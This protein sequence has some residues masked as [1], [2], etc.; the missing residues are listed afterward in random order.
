MSTSS[1][2]SSWARILSPGD[3]ILGVAAVPWLLVTAFY[4]ARD[5]DP[6]YGLLVALAS[7]VVT[8][9]E[10]A[11]AGRDDPDIVTGTSVVAFLPWSGSV[12][13]S[14]GV[15]YDESDVIAKPLAT[16]QELWRY[17]GVPGEFLCDGRVTPLGNHFYM[18]GFSCCCSPIRTFGRRTKKWT[19]GNRHSHSGCDDRLDPSRLEQEEK[20][21]RLID[22]CWRI[23]KPRLGQ[24]PT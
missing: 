7:A 16:R 13:G 23:R 21:A 6:F 10:A 8:P 2:P 17:H 15:V 1:V 5:V 3:L 18:A 14:Y 20:P 9:L 12:T 19:N 24:R 11:R 22:P 4:C